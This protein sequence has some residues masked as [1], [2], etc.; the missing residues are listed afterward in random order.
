MSIPA[1]KKIYLDNAASTPVDTRV[2]VAM[3]PY[4]S[5]QFGNAGSL[6]RFGREAKQALE[7]SRKTIANIIHAKATEVVFT[8]SATEANNLAL[9]G[10]LWASDKKKHLIVSATEHACVLVTAQWLKEQGYGLTILPVDRYGLA[11][12][13]NVKKARR[14]DT[15]LVSV[16]HA[17]NEIGTINAIGEIG[18]LCRSK[19]ILFHTDAVQTFGILPIDVNRLNIDLLTAS[20]HKIYGPHGVGMLYV[21]TGVKL[22]PLINGGG[23]E[24]GLRSGS[25]NIAGIVGFAKAAQIMQTEAPR[26][27]KRLAVLRDMFING[28]LQN[29]SGVTLG[30]HPTQRTPNNTHFVFDDLLGEALVLALDVVGIACSTGSACQSLADEDSH[31]VRACELNAAGALRFTLG[32]QTTKKDILC[33]L[34]VLPKVVS[35]LRALS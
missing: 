3:R 13:S 29:I 24:F 15:V 18:K 31:V 22:T 11:S 17:N 19:K 1:S 23:Q 34:E 33:V 10:A 6:H 21:R 25:P 8:S 4:F 16:M 27:R 30:G 32:R 28:V 26:E 2:L 12:V 14:K 35:K 20:S 9:K 5:E 7:Q